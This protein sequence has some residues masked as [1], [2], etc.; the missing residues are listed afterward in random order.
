MMWIRVAAPLAIC[1]LLVPAISIAQ[2][3]DE[4]I[5]GISD[6]LD[7]CSE[8]INW[9]QDDTDADDCGNLCDADYNNDGNVGFADFGIFLQLCFKPASN[10][11]VCHVEPIPDCTCGFADFGFFVSHFNGVPGPSGTT[12]GTTACP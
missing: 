3:P 12:L 7:N 9:G 11:L 5:D 8:A 2:E 10:E 6:Q 1:A 4:D